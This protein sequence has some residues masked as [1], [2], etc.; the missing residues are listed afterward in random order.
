MIYRCSSPTSLGD[1]CLVLGGSKTYPIYFTSKMYPTII[2]TLL[3]WG[4]ALVRSH[5]HFNFSGPHLEIAVFPIILPLTLLG[6]AIC[7]FLIASEC[8]LG[9][10]CFY[11]VTSMFFK[12]IKFEDV[13]F[14]LLKK[15]KRNLVVI[16]FKT[17]DFVMR[18]LNFLLQLFC[19]YCWLYAFSSMNIILAVLSTK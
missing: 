19:R 16:H 18:F 11:F 17:L 4:L 12:L 7:P 14:V 5:L 15:K 3:M 6:L 9:S 10:L 1:S 13:T 2:K 8:L